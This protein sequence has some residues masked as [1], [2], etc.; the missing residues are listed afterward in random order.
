[1]IKV[2]KSHKELEL[3][4]DSRYEKELSILTQKTKR[5]FLKN[6]NKLFSFT[7]AAPPR[8]FLMFDNSLKFV[9]LKI[10]FYSIFGKSCK[11]L[12]KRFI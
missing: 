8:I 9:I 4:N 6:Q 10:Y 2:M 3:S 7:Q 12:N 11:V 5:Q 1:M